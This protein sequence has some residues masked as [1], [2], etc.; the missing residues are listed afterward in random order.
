MMLVF[1][2]TLFTGLVSG[3]YPALYLSG[4]KPVGILKGGNI[5][6]KNT[7]KELWARN[8]LVAFQ[9]VISMVL[10]V[11]VLVV[12]QQMEFIQAKN[13]GFEKANVISFT[14]EGKLAEDPEPFLAELKQIPGV[15]QASYMDGDRKSTRLNSSH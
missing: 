10:I 7:V 9:F 6:L 15:A 12:Y 14:S 13:L 2:I 5:P 8:G 1:G 3:S 11:S 4:F